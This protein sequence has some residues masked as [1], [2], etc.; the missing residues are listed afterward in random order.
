M[1]SDIAALR[2]QRDEAWDELEEERARV[3]RLN[4]ALRL[5]FREY[6]LSGP[7]LSEAEARRL[8]R[9]WANDVPRE[10]DEQ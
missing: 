6:V 5:M 2:R 3:R 4:D 9:T 8:H 1:E 10:G 7:A